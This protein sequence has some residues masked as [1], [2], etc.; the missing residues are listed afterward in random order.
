MAPQTSLLVKLGQESKRCT[1]IDAPGACRSI[2][3]GAANVIASASNA[4]R[5]KH[6]TST[7]S[8]VQN[9]AQF[10]WA[11]FDDDSEDL[12]RLRQKTIETLLPTLNGTTMMIHLEVPS[13]QQVQELH[14][15]RCVRR[16]GDRS[17]NWTAADAAKLKE[18]MQVVLKGRCNIIVHSA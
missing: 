4:I 7:L 11:R 15:I 9:A 1:V 3:G 12:I 10:V 6:L 14:R 2:C 18:A 8:K 13:L 5:L 17:L 16:D